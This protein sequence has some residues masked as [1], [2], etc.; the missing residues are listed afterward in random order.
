MLQAQALDNRLVATSAD[1]VLVDRIVPGAPL[2]IAFGFVSWT[3]R[4]AFDFYGRL[5]KLEQASGQ[6]LNKILVRDSGNAWYHRR[7]AGLGSHVDETAQALRELVRRIAPSHVTTVGQSMGAY[8]AV[9]Y[10]L[11][12]DAQQ[13]VAFGPLSFLDVQQARL[14]H[15]L[16]W[17]PVMESLAQDPPPSGYYDL[18]ALCRARATDDT[19]LHLVFGTRPDAARPDAASAGAGA[20]ESVNLDA[21]HAQRLAAFGRCTLHPYPQ[22]GHAVVQHL[23]DTKRINGLLAA[24]ILG[25]TLEDEPMPEIGAAWQD[26]VAENLRLGCA[27]EQLVAVLQQHGFSLASSMAAVDAAR[28]KAI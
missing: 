26:W 10:G 2:V 21:M 8:A 9:M 27:G 14:Y 12:L 19:Q 3:T 25:L 17:L 7:I 5:R 23:I 1:D 28:A 13:I 20:S 24:C 16:R 4:P 6:H 15:E 11:L 18:A 22:S